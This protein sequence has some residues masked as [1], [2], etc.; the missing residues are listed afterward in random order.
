[1]QS[2][3]SQIKIGFSIEKR[4][5]TAEQLEAGKRLFSRLIE[6]ARQKE[7]IKAKAGAQAGAEAPPAAAPNSLSGGQILQ[8]ELKVC[9]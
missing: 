9:F 4:P 8:S 1:M 7:I 5:M 2:S 3:K 6:R